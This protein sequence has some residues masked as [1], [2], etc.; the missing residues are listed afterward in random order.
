MTP[1]DKKQLARYASKSY[2]TRLRMKAIEMLGGKCV[3]C[4]FSDER[5]LQ[6]DHINGGG[7][8][9]RAGSSGYY[10]HMYKEIIAGTHIHPVQL[11]CAN[12]NWIKRTDNNEMHASNILHVK[13]FKIDKSALEHHRKEISEIRS[14]QIAV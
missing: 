14:M 9:L 3:K 2:K 1:E 4:G 7:N 10:V 13:T 12:C 11:L 6:F 5:A 8:K